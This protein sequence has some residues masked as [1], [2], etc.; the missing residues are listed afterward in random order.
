MTMI[1]PISTTITA[2]EYLRRILRGQRQVSVL[3]HRGYF[4]VDQSPEVCF[5]TVTN[6][7]KG[8]P[9]TITHVWF[10]TDPNVEVLDPRLAKTL[11]SSEVW[12]TWCPM[13]QLHGATGVERLARVKL[14]TQRRP[15]KSHRDRK[16]RP[17][18]LI[19]GLAG[20][21]ELPAWRSLGIT[22]SASAI[23][24]PPSTGTKQ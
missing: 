3:T 20:V 4:K 23:F 6:H 1:E 7:S 12:E 10:A 8:Q 24:L 22:T 19:P 21:T 2:W 5:V 9:V 16:V 11:Q 17:E 14:S 15:I 18:G 13:S